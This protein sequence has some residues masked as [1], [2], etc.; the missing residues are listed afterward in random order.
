MRFQ[1]GD[2]KANLVLI[3][4]VFNSEVATT[5][6][7]MGTFNGIFL[8]FDWFTYMPLFS[9]PSSTSTYQLQNTI[10]LLKCVC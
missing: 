8:G 1:W 2:P 5:E 10:L 9:L 7:L 3:Y 6:N 4:S